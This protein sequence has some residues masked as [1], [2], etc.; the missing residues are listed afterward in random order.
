MEVGRPHF[1]TNRV[2]SFI[3]VLGKITIFPVQ[4]LL[5]PSVPS[6]VWQVMRVR[7]DSTV[8]LWRIRRNQKLDAASTELT[9]FNSWSKCM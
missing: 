6:C 7:I 3:G 1:M 8:T 9:G 2:T 5:I 4:A